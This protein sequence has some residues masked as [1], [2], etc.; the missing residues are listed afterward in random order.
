MKLVQYLFSTIALG[1]VLAIEG[2][3]TNSSGTAQRENQQPK[4]LEI[5]AIKTEQLELLDPTRNR[6]VPVALYHPVT[7]GSRPK[8]ALLSHGYGGKHTGYSF[9]AENLAAQGYL[10]ASVQHELPGD[11]PMP[12]T[13]NAREVRRPIWDRG[14][15]TLLFVRQEMSRRYPELDV[16]NLLLVGHS[17]GGDVSVLLA[18]QQ[19]KLVEKVISLDNR[20]MPLPRISRPRVLSIRSS[21]QVADEGVLPT[22]AE[23]QTLGMRIVRLTNTIHNDM[24]DGA[25]DAQKAEMSA[26]ILAFLKS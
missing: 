16:D 24:W 25:T 15:R 1:V 26:I 23:Q 18:H 22:A 21:D 10:V 8:L 20:R 19:P 14:V 9:I 4:A 11:E 5:H 7:L 12:T 6:A 2:C 3:T 17:N 13:G